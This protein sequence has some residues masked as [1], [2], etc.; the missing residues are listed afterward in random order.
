MI[1]KG[2]E[3]YKKTQKM[4]LD[5]F[6]NLINESEDWKLEFNEIIENNNWLADYEDEESYKICQSDTELLYF[7]DNGK[8]QTR[9]L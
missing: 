2:T 5:E 7:D 9:A 1:T 6:A 8:A 4:T 3:E